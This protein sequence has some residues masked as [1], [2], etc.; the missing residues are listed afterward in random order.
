MTDGI[1]ALQNR[2]V[3]AAT[4]HSILNEFFPWRQAFVPVTTQ[5]LRFYPLQ[6][7]TTRENRRQEDEPSHTHTHTRT[8]QRRGKQGTFVSLVREGE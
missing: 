3:C 7:R 1:P 2:Q 4:N 6:Q 5:E 8:L